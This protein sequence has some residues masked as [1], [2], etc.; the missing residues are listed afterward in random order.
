MRR[1]EAHAFE[2]VDE[3]QARNSLQESV[4]TPLPYTNEFTFCLVSV[5][6]WHP[7][8]RHTLANLIKYVYRK[9]DLSPVFAWW[10]HSTAERR[11]YC[12]PRKFA[13]HELMREARGGGKLVR[14]DCRKCEVILDLRLPVV[15]F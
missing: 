9:A 10:T 3:L 15:R 8:V 14:G 13:T 2:T 6:L 1:G 12:S 4:L 11:S 5:L 7:S